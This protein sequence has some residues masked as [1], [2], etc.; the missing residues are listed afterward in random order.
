M[1]MS[2]IYSIDYLNKIR[3]MSEDKRVSILCSFVEF[4]NVDEFNRSV[5]I[6]YIIDEC[7][8][9]GLNSSNVCKESEQE[10]Q[11]RKNFVKKMFMDCLC[12]V[13]P[14][15]DSTEEE[16]YTL[17]DMFDK[18]I[19]KSNKQFDQIVQKYMNKLIEKNEMFPKF[20]DAI[21]MN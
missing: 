16:R 11:E 15:D 14:F 4:V 1:Q 13:I 9:V 10:V 18:N 17:Y 12:Q 5:A 2:S 20:Y 6:K 8:I 19:T 21:F 3:S 7:G